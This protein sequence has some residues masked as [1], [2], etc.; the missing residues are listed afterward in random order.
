MA[1]ITYF[2]GEWHD[3]SPPVMGPMTQSF[4][5]G[6]TVFDGEATDPKH[7]SLAVSALFTEPQP[8]DSLK[9]QASASVG[10]LGEPYTHIARFEEAEE[11]PFFF[12]E[13]VLRGFDDITSLP[14]EAL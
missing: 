2:D 13:Q 11:C 1:A 9:N 14:D 4:M 10:A 3:G 6:S 12:H 5:H 7:N 8:E